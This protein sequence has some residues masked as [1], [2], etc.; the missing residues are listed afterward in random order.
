[1]PL[2]S[3]VPY[4]IWVAVTSFTDLWFVTDESLLVLEAGKF[5]VKGL[6]DSMSGKG[7]LHGSWHFLALFSHSEWY[8]QA[9]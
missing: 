2:Q 5:K 8:R 6:V 1:M 4:S 9:L 3:M 7:L